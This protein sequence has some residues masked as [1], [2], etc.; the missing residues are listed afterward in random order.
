MDDKTQLILAQIF[1]EN[2]DTFLEEKAKQKIGEYIKYLKEEGYDMNYG[3]FVQDTNKMDWQNKALFYKVFYD[4][5]DYAMDKYKLTQN[6]IDFLCR[7]GRYL[8][9]EMNL[10]VDQEN[11]PLNQTGLAACMKI[12]IRT[13]QR[14]LKPLLDSFLIYKIEFGNECF[15]IVNPYLLFIGKNINV[16]IPTLFEQLGYIRSNK[17]SR[18]NR[19]SKI[20]KRTAIKGVQKKDSDTID[21]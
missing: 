9:W 1:K 6:D 7:L 21:M 10:I 14:S 4:E 8:K 17:D 12:S 18:D 11:T 19:C 20:S 5:L 15:Y 2:V 3:I 16:Q 13:L